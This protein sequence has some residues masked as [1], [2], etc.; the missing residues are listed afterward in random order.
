M[1][2]RVNDSTNSHSH[3]AF[4]EA[5]SRIKNSSYETSWRAGRRLERFTEFHSRYSRELN[6]MNESLVIWVPIGLL[7]PS[8]LLARKHEHG[9]RKIDSFLSLAMQY[10]PSSNVTLSIFEKSSWKSAR[11]L[12]FQPKRTSKWDEQWMKMRVSVFRRQTRRYTVEIR[13]NWEHPGNISLRKFSTS[14]SLY[15]K[16]RPDFSDCVTRYQHNFK[17][18]L[19][20]RYLKALISSFRVFSVS[21]SDF[22]SELGHVTTRY[23][24]SSKENFYFRSVMRSPM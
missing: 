24:L 4:V 16:F 22:P 3:S 19:H 13:E 5:I 11:S 17:F 1:K 9:K 6:L 20:F 2:W 23:E 8:S 7:P 18:K 10:F 14:Q 21:F 12:Q 15:F